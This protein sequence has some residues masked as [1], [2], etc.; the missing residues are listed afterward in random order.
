[1]PA[2]RRPR[3]VLVLPFARQLFRLTVAWA[4]REYLKSVVDASL[5]RD[6]SAV[7][8]PVR[9]GSVILVTKI[10]RG[11]NVRVGA[12]RIH[13]VDLR[14]PRPVGHEGDPVAVG[15]EGR[16]DAH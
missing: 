9:A 11:E 3:R 14:M 12:V 16:R 2:I 5:K 1:M 13:Y 10:E 15:T 8:G 6:L 7:R 4:H